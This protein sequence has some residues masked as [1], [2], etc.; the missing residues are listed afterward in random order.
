MIV[1]LSGLSIFYDFDSYIMPV[2]CGDESETVVIYQNLLKFLPH[3]LI[4]RLRQIPGKYAVLYPAIPGSHL[5][6]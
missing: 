2:S 5:S 3:F 6:H 1:I 4:Q